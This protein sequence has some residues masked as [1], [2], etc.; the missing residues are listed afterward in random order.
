MTEQTKR[1]DERHYSNVP[2][3]NN[4]VLS[5]LVLPELDQGEFTSLTYT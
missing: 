3:L 5:G 2:L 4:K 1:H